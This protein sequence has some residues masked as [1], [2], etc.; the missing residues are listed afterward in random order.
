MS[1][2]RI[3]QHP[4]HVLGLPTYAVHLYLVYQAD[5]GDEYVIRAGAEDPLKPT[6]GEMEVQVNVP[7]ERSADARRGDTPADRSSTELSFPGHDAG[8]AWT[9]MVKYARAIGAADYGYELLSVNSNAFAMAMVRAAGDPTP[10]DQLPDGLDADAAVGYKNWRTIVADI[11]PPAN[12]D[13]VGTAAG[14]L[15]RGIQADDVLRGLGG[16]DTVFGG[17]GDD[18]A[19]GGDGADRLWGEHGQDWLWGN[20]GDDLLIGWTGNDR[21]WGGEGADTLAGNA[22]ADT[23]SGEG[24]ADRIAGGPGDDLLAGG[25]GADVFDF[26]EGGGADRVADFITGTD[27]L[28]ILSDEVS[29]FA[30]L[31]LTPEGNGLRVGFGDT[32]VVLLHV[33]PDDFGPGDVI[34]PAAGDA[35]VT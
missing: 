10:A 12:G 20:L 6:G 34:L 19:T 18:R 23:I 25:A 27:R 5:Q 16:D 31:D 28:R 21:L 8:E 4:V 11:P 17:R 32:S 13:V 30:D 2:I 24:G 15:L 14:D 22:D 1:R 7:I 35:L 33:D 9:I 29:R 26:G 3:E